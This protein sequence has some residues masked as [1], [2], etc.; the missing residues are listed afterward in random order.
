MVSFFLKFYPRQPYKTYRYGKYSKTV[1]AAESRNKI[2]KQFKNNLLKD[3]SANKIKK[4]CCLFF[5]QIILI[6]LLILQK[7]IWLY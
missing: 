7:Y 3:L 1:S 6:T 2:Q 4:V 5:S